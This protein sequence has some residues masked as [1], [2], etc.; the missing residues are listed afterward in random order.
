MIKCL[1]LF[2]NVGIGETY[3]RKFGVEVVVANELLPERAEFY[4][5]LHPNTN[6]ICGDITSKKV[7]DDIVKA[8]RKHK[9]VDLLVATPPCQGMSIANAKRAEKDDPRNSLIRNVVTLVS[10]TKPKYVL[11]E[12]VPGMSRKSTVILDEG[13]ASTSIMSY[14]MDEVGPYYDIVYR[15]LNASDYGTPHHRKRLITLLSRKDCELWHHPTPCQNQITVRGCIGGLPSLE[16]G[17]DSDIKWHSMKHKIHNDNHIKWM[18]H[19]PTGKTAFDNPEH[20]PK[21]LDCD[22]PLA[23]GVGWPNPPVRAYLPTRRIKGFKT[24]Y[25]RMEWD[26]PAPTVTMANGSVNSQNNCH[27]GEQMPDGTYS[28]ARVLTIKELIHIVGLPSDWID[29]MEHTKERE[30]LT[31]KVLGECFPPM[32]A[33]SIIKTLPILRDQ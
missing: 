4:K 3:F 15:V 23:K 27:P 32:M 24:T 33:A 16:S 29:D 5:H 18:R 20:F 25:K 26:E 31:R 6:M 7:Q 11:I 30:N 8:C 9:G 28:D 14:L 19:T 2:S 22:I 10:R 13:G 21:I 17:E 12:N 1:S